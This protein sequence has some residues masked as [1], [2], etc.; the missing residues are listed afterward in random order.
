MTDDS[1]IRTQG[2][3]R[4]LLQA[5]SHPG[6]VYTLPLPALGAERQNREAISGLM[7]IIETLLDSEVTF[8]LVSGSL[9]LAQEIEGR[10]GS[11][12]TSLPLAD[13][14]VIAGNSGDGEIGA[15]KRG[16][17]EYPDDGA[18][19]IYLV[20]SISAEK[21]ETR[22]A[23]KGPGIARLAYLSLSGLGRGDLAA[24]GEANTEFPFGI[25]IILV[26]R[27]GSVACIPR[28]V[29]IVEVA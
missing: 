1:S 22:L 23:L 17:I 3:F 15:A 29:S 26:D 18:T 28:S 7:D 12:H 14:V 6:R 16:T 9:T 20:D 2:T 11:N 5:M 19:V 13:F 21:G 27:N 25:D 8:T 10:T 24:I 4:V